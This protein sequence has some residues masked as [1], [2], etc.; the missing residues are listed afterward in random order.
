[1][2]TVNPLGPVSAASEPLLR[3][4]GETQRRGHTFTRLREKVRSVS[5]SV[6]GA[7]EAQQECDEPAWKEVNGA[8]QSARP[9]WLNRV[10]AVR[11]ITL[12][13]EPWS[14][15]PNIDLI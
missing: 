9:A 15:S 13:L 12:G 1:M 11:A 6:A 14:P 5:K 8:T 7:T 4:P 2:G 10:C 3:L